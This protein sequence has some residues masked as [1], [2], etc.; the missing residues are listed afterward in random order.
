MGKSKIWNKILGSKIEEDFEEWEDFDEYED[1]HEQNEYETDALSEQEDN[2]AYELN[3]D[4]YHE[5][6]VDIYQDENN[7]YIE[8]F[9]PAVDLDDIDI[10]LA[11]DMIHIH[12]ERV[13]RSSAPEDKYFYKELYWGSFERKIILP[14]EIDID[15]ASATEKGGLLQIVLPKINKSKKTKL[16]VRSSK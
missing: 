1:S 3:R 13:R 4:L 8:A 11:R 12:G 14:E 6:P 7:I 15:S 2:G 5:L 10:Q 9:I 16:K